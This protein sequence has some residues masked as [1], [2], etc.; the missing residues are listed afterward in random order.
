MSR[1]SKISMRQLRYLIAVSEHGGFS[2][3]ADALRI[4]Q[5][6]LGLQIKA[7][8]EIVETKLFRRHARGVDTTDAGKILVQDA[9]TMLAILETSVN[10]IR[11]S[12]EHS[13]TL[14]VGTTATAGRAM[15][16]SLIAAE[17]AAQGRFRLNLVESKSVQLM[18]RLRAGELDA[19]FVYT[20]ERADKSR[21]PLFQEEFVLV[22]RKDALP[23]GER[24]SFAALA[25]LT[26]LLRP[27]DDEFRNFLEQKANEHAIRLNVG[28]ES[29]AA[30]FKAELIMRGFC[31]IIPYSAYRREIAGGE[32]RRI[33]FEPPLLRTMS[34]VMAPG[35]NTDARSF[36][37]NAALEAV[38]ERI[39]DAALGWLPLG[40]T[41]A[42]VRGGHQSSDPGNA[43]RFSAQS[44]ARM[45]T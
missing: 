33:G 10:K 13:E 32:F 22:A 6:A 28:L 5:P 31:V 43:M 29:D 3:A 2:A 8:E 14:R 21:T 7:L 17:R 42:R 41:K 16:S 40:P 30:P 26:L 4:S 44:N 36:L 19:A 11:N 35:L 1:L 37:T 12:R 34:L 45:E 38:R 39:G 18:R 9:R 27:N 20:D 24:T 23:D 25:D 15:I